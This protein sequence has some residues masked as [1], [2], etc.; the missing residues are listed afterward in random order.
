[1]DCRGLDQQ[2]ENDRKVWKTSKSG[3]RKVSL[4]EFGV[5]SG[6]LLNQKFC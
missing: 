2:K 5:N 3:L 6:K 1:M 4:K